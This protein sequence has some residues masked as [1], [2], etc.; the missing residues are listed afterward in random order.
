MRSRLNPSLLFALTAAILPL[1]ATAEE[2]IADGGPAFININDGVV[3]EG[4]GSV[5]FTVT[6]HP[7]GRVNANSWWRTFDGTAVAPDDYIAVTGQLITLGQTSADTQTYSIVVTI[8]DDTDFEGDETFTVGLGG[9]PPS[10]ANPS[11]GPPCLFLEDVTGQGTI[12]N[13]DPMNAPPVAEAG[14]PYS[15]PEGSPIALNG[16]G[17]TDDH[18]IVLYEWDCTNDGTYDTSSASPTGA[19]CS[20]ADNGA[21]TVKLRVTDA[22][23]ATDE[24]TAAVAVSNVAP[25]IATIIV[26]SGSIDE[27]QSVTVSGTFSDPGTADTFTAAALWSDGASSP[28]VLGA[29]TFSTTRSFADD[30]PATATASDVFTV[31]V[32]I[33]DDDGGSGN[34]TSPPV[35]VHNVDPTVDTIVLSATSIDEGDPAVTVTGTFSDPALGVASETFEGTATWSDGAT[36][37]VTVGDGTFSTSRSFADDHPATGTLSDVFTVTIEITD[38]DTGSGSDT[39]DELTVHDVA[40]T[41]EAPATAPEPSNEGSPVTSSAAFDD[42]AYGVATESFTC[43]VDAGDGE[44]PAAGTVAGQTCTAASHTYADN[45]SY[46]VTVEVT[47]DDTA[48]GSEVAAHQVL[49]VDPTITATTNS[50]EECGATPDG[51]AVEVSADFSDPGFDNPV[52]GT[53]EDF[54]ASSI[55]WGDS[56]VDAATVSET[57]G[58]VGVAT[59]GTVSGSHVYA[60]GGIFTITITVEDDD[61]GT[62]TA[63]LTAL[64]TGAGLDP[65]GLLGIVGTDFNDVFN[66]QTKG[67]SIEVQSPVLGPGKVAFPT[68]QVVSIE[69]H[70]CDGHDQVHVAKDVAKPAVLDGGPGDDHLRAGSGLTQLLGGPGSDHLFAGDSGNVLEGEAGADDLN[71]GKGNDLLFGGDGDDKLAGDKGDDFLDGGPG[72]DDCNPGQGTDTV[73]N[74]EP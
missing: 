38:D 1:P 63:T 22:Q 50:A 55:D 12:E 46:D 73:I 27:G 53:V 28:V 3:S 30:H 47:D 68:S 58:S 64:V 26:S 16:S 25:T 48:S 56:T 33:T 17:S 61:G 19:S 69:A 37:A 39:S 42:P 8:N 52:A 6:C 32:T 9:Q 7:C 60:S 31:Q 11:V 20:Y 13:D 35:T 10:E 34:A 18:G 21:Y 72:T 59:T 62:D 44:G 2:C 49:N 57:P 5:T 51:V 74:C 67:S 29:G 24:D 36:T 40:P 4:G 70:T 65:S 54:D 23:A 41:V 45:G 71:G 14:G 43:T 66:V 15:G